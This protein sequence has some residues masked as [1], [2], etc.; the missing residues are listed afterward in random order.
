MVDFGGVYLFDEGGHL[1]VVLDVL[2]VEVHHIVWRILTH[3]APFEQLH[4]LLLSHSHEVLLLQ[5]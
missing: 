5:A 2:L 1:V 4:V 3:Y